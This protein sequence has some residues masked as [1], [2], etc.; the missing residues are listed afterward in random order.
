MKGNEV[1]S[2]CLSLTKEEELLTL[3]ARVGLEHEDAHRLDRLLGEGP[4]WTKIMAASARLGIRPLLYLHLSSGERA[5]FVP[6]EVK[7]QLAT[8]Y[9]LQALRSVRMVGCLRRV[10]DLANGAGIPVILLKGAFLGQWIYQDIALRP[11]SDIDVLCPLGQ[12]TELH[13]LLTAEGFMAEFS[14]D[15]YHSP[16]HAE[17]FAAH[18]SHLPPVYDHKVTRIE[19]HSWPF[20]TLKPVGPEQMEDLWAKSMW[21]QWD[22]LR[23]GSLSPEYQ[24]IHLCAHFHYHMEASSVGLHWFCDIHEILRHYGKAIDWES[25][26]RT[27]DSLELSPGVKAILLVLK[28]HWNRDIPRPVGKYGKVELAEI[29]RRQYSQDSGPFRPAVWSNYCRNLRIGVQVDGWKNRLYFI[30]KLVFPSKAHM[31]YRYQPTNAFMLLLWYAL[32]PLI[33]AGRGIDSL[34]CHAVYH[35]RNAL[36]SRRIKGS[37]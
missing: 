27:A 19:V 11:M 31:K 8:D 16:L 32:H 13:K 4:D 37:R 24:V 25:L 17:V 12:H 34:Y 1:S 30:W 33:Q 9:K 21:H 6:E 15:A 35:G 36:A 26:Y 14:G 5:R 2:E 10:L 3:A 29:L 18:G 28:Q 20:H 22:G 7:A 23:F